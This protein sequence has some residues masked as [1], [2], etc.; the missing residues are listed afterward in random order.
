M[1]L[2][3]IV[4]LKLGV[5]DKR[6]YMWAEAEY[7]LEKYISFKYI[8]LIFYIKILLS[9]NAALLVH[10]CM[11]IFFKQSL[12]DV[13]VILDGNSLHLNYSRLRENRQVFKY[14]WYFYKKEILR[15][16][17][18]VVYF[19]IYQPCNNYIHGLYSFKL[20]ISWWEKSKKVLER[21]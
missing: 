17:C 16:Y 3:S 13:N 10:K 14:S 11:F 5:V 21:R 1:N 9:E 12:Q 18:Q 4:P 2:F 15:E 7:L 20:F 19:H 6:Y 8:T